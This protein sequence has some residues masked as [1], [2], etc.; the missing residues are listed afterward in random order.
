MNNLF[1]KRTDYF[2]LFNENETLI[3]EY[4]NRWNKI[5]ETNNGYIP[6]VEK[7]IHELGLEG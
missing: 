7:Y 5:A 1:L 3:S 2:D 6:N 4:L